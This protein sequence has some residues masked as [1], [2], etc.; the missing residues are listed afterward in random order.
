M[1]RMES[2][3][4][5]EPTYVRALVV[6]TVK[7]SKHTFIL[8]NK[9]LT[10]ASNIDVLDH[11]SLFLCLASGTD[12]KFEVC[13]IAWIHILWDKIDSS[14]FVPHIVP[15]L[16]GFIFS[17]SSSFPHFIGL[18]PFKPRAPQ[19]KSENKNDI[20]ARIISCLK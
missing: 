19:R 6:L 5:L 3:F 12:S 10:K 14:S 2:S 8:T 16:L 9:C 4:R 20:R 17:F 11:D 13:G 18:E 15:C 7:A 1:S